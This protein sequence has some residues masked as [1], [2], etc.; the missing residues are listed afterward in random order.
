LVYA[1]LECGG[2][3]IYS[4]AKFYSCFK[5]KRAETKH[6]VWPGDRNQWW[7][8][9]SS[10]FKFDVSASS[11]LAVYLFERGAESQ[12]GHQS[13]S[14][15]WINLQPDPVL[16]TWVAGTQWLDVQDGT[17]KVEIQVS[18]QEE[19]V[20]P[21]EDSGVWRVRRDYRFGDLV[22]VEKRDTNRAFAMRTIRTPDAVLGSDLVHKL[23]HPF[24]APVEYAFSSPEG[25]SLLSPVANGGHLFPYLQ[26]E[27]R[28]E[29]DKARLYSAELTSAMEY[30]HSRGILACLKPENVVL[31]PYGHISLCS[32]GLYVSNTPSETE[33]PAPELILGQEASKTADWWGLGVILYEMLIGVPPFYHEDGQERQHRI[34]NQTVQLP[35]GLP[36]AARNILTKLL[37]KDPVTRLGANGA[38]EVKAHQFLDGIDWF[39]LTHRR[40]KTISSFEPTEAETV[41]RV[42]PDKGKDSRVYHETGAQRVS[43]E[44]VAEKE[45]RW[46]VF[47]VDFWYPINDKGEDD[48]IRGTTSSPENDEEW[49]LLWDSGSQA[50]HFHNRITGEK[51][52]IHSDTRPPHASRGEDL[53]TQ[54]P[55]P[56]QKKDALEVALEAGYSNRVVSQVLKYDVDL[57]DAILVR[58][59][60]DGWALPPPNRP[61]RRIWLTPLEWAVEKGNAELVKL[62]LHHGSDANFCTFPQEGPALVRAVKTRNQ[63]LV[64]MLLPKSNRITSTRALC[65]AIEQQDTDIVT[66]LLT[67]GVLPDFEPSDIP[68]PVIP[69]YDGGCTF[70]D[71]PHNLGPRLEA[72]DFTPPLIRAARLGNASLVRLLRAHGAD[73]NSA[74]HVLDIPIRHKPW[75]EPPAPIHFTCGR[76]AQLAKELGHDEVVQLLLE[77]GADVSLPPPVWA[78]QG[79]KCPLIPR[80]VY[81]RVT[82]GLEELAAARRGSRGDA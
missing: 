53:V 29:V 20:P 48:T 54:G 21:L 23:K 52:P 44:G 47:G 22:R 39:G 70:V 28:F 60:P 15:G 43:G 50:F 78:A 13:T 11:E 5:T 35:T 58:T 3:Q 8:E 80:S 61:S 31:D 73:V 81:L 41:F 12:T 72:K 62:F 66:S 6:V 64:E 42:D 10:T 16:G 40:R 2:A 76:A 32:P 75:E 24:L 36:A 26:K 30:L 63:R 77:G 69:T 55:R 68:P 45:I 46:D 38:S 74:Y 49:E 27:R 34:T 67:H 65:H 71:L 9:R 37:D 59:E 14:L 33:I 18:Y 56:S 17:G 25:L 7:G 4:E 57:N 79:H 51:R 1:I 82:A 19:N